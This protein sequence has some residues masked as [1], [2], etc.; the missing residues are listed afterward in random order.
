MEEA[1]LGHTPT[2]DPRYPY[3]HAY[4]FIRS[5]VDDYEPTLGFRVPTVSRAQCAQMC[6]AIAP[7]LGMTVEDLAKRIADH[8][9]ATGGAA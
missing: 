5:H 6:G 4:D 1:T 8:A 3:T 9:K 2:V 7:A